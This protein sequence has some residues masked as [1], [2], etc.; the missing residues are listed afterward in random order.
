[1]FLVFRRPCLLYLVLLMHICIKYWMHF[2][3]F[4][5]TVH[6][7]LFT[8]AKISRCTI[9]MWSNGHC[10]DSAML[11]GG[12]SRLQRVVNKGYKFGNTM[13]TIYAVRR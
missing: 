12:S 9:E 5:A 6:T 1:M 10:I 7:D 11:Q 8:G 3:F 2:F 13:R 4:P